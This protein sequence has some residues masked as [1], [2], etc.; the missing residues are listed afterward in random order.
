VKRFIA[1][2]WPLLLNGVLMFGIF[3]G[4]RVIVGSHYTMATLG[5]YAVAFGLAMAPTVMLARVNAALFLP[6]LSQCQDDP[7]RFA[8]RYQRAALALSVMAGLLAGGFI[9]AGPALVVLLY[10]EAYA[11]AAG[12]IGWLG[13]MQAVRLM[14][15]APSQAAM[16]LGETRNMMIAN[17]VRTTAL[18]GV[19]LAALAHGPLWWIAACGLVGELLAALT[20]AALLKRQHRIAWGL[21]LRPASIG[22]VLTLIAVV[23]AMLEQD[24][25]LRSGLYAAVLLMA[26]GAGAWLWRQQKPA[27]PVAVGG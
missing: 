23:L 7:A 3:Q 20:A 22:A 18:A 1:F 13:A 12:V 14:R 17:A 25:W 6:A 26:V 19:L 8:A 10:G 27:P 11:A 5:A 9:L 15:A 16:A 24:A 4:D 2:G 21:T